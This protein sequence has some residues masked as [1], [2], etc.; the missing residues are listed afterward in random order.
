MQSKE[1]LSLPE[2]GAFQE[3]L[4]QSRDALH[5]AHSTK[6]FEGPTP[7]R[8]GSQS[9]IRFCRQL[10]LHLKMLYLAFSS[11]IWLTKAL[12]YRKRLYS[13]NGW[14]AML[15]PCST[16]SFSMHSTSIP[17]SCLMLLAVL[18]VCR[19]GQWFVLC[20]LFYL[21]IPTTNGIISCLLPCV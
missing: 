10:A 19:P 20:D 21:Y 17:K 4:P 14:L 12:G 1:H 3:S 16:D 8:M 15:N 13:N 18:I 6:L 5:H 7:S 9:F 2:G 11:S